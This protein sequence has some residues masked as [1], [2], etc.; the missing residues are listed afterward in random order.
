M[1]Y[2]IFSYLILG[3]LLMSI[4]SCSSH[5]KTNNREKHIREAN[6]GKP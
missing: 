4:T 3:L 6:D 1:R 2:R 5:Q